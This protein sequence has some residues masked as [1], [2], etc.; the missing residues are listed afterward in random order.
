MRADVGGAIALFKS[1]GIGNSLLHKVGLS[2]V[3]RVSEAIQAAP[4]S[5]LTPGGQLL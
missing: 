3:A 2:A 4:G 1:A 5:D